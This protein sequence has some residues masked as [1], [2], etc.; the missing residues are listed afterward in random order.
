MPG[1]YTTPERKIK[2]LEN[3]NERLLRRNGELN[4]ALSSERKRNKRKRA[5]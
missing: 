1:T 3:Y 2:A 5:K 4:V